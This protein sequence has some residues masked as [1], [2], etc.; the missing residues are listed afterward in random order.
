M[1]KEILEPFLILPYGN[2]QDVVWFIDGRIKDEY[3][4]LVSL[5]Y[6]GISNDILRHNII[7]VVNLPHKII[8]FHFYPTAYIEKNSGRGGQ[9]LIIGY[10]ID[11][12]CF[13]KRYCNLIYACSLFF[14]A[15]VRYGQLDISKNIPT[16]FLTKINAKHYNDYIRNSLCKVRANMLLIME[17]EEQHTIEKHN[18]RLSEVYTL[19]GKKRYLRR[20]YWIVVDTKEY[21]KFQKQH[22]VYYLMLKDNDETEK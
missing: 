6:D 19:I 11:K 17:N 5:A 20:K 13:R 2:M 10:I 8:V 15:I 18:R 7:K 9:N 4:S 3:R 14:E 22:A 1:I 16:Q 21:E 12:G